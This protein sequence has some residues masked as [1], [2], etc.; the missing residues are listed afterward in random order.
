MIGVAPMRIAATL[1]V[2]LIHTMPIS[3]TEL[4][5][6]SSSSPALLINQFSRFAVPFFFTISGFFWGKSISDKNNIFLVWKKYALRFSLLFI[7]WT[8]IYSTPYMRI[9]PLLN[10]EDTILNLI[11]QTYWNLSSFATHPLT[12]ILE[13]SK[14]HLWFLPSLLICVSISSVFVKNKI[15]PVLYIASILLYVIRVL[16]KSYS[17]TPYGIEIDINTRDGPFFGLIFFATGYYLSITCPR[18]TSPRYGLVVLLTGFIAQAIELNILN[19][20]YDVSKIQDY[21]FSTYLM[22]IGAA[23]ICIT[24][25]SPTSFRLD[26]LEF[27]G[28]LTLGIYLVHFIFID[29]IIEISKK[30]PEF[31]TLTNPYIFPSIV[32]ISSIV[33]S[34]TVNLTKHIKWLVR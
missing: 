9:I 2:I 33:F 19:I 28:K 26:R 32:F 15:T 31:I 3:F 6:Y 34:L 24:Q 29:A 22:G 17:N 21:C 13:G 4:E 12:L 11:K 8:V 27:I 18:R 16:G 7:S 14:S 10:Q 30:S 23:M 20:K 25:K 1:A 5:G